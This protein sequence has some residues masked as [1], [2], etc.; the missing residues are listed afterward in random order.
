MAISE[1]STAHDAGHCTQSLHGCMV[2]AG[3]AKLLATVSHK[4]CY[5]TLSHNV[6]KCCR[7]SNFFHLQSP[8]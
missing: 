5:Y 2:Q 8:Q 3:A 6:A 4:W 7:F 1:T